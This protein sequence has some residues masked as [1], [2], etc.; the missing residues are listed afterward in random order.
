MASNTHLLIA[1]HQGRPHEEKVREGRGSAY[2][3]HTSQSRG[4]IPKL[5]SANKHVPVGP[6]ER[7]ASGDV[8]PQL[9]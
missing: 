7:F 8:V 1:R 6:E 3:L 5:G 9:R 4:Y 2:M